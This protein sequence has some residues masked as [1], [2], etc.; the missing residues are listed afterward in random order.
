MADALL[1]EKILTGDTPPDTEKHYYKKRDL[2]LNLLEG[3]QIIAL[4]GHIKVGLAHPGADLPSCEKC[5]KIWE[6]M[7]DE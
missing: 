1:E 6:T 2:D 4:C 5:V 3:V 7:K